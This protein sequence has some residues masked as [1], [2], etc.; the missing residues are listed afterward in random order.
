[1]ADCLARPSLGWVPASQGVEFKENHI[2]HGLATP[3][4]ARVQAVLGAY[5]SAWHRAQTWQ[6]LVYNRFKLLLPGLANG[7]ARPSLGWV[8]PGLLGSKYPRPNLL[9][10]KKHTSN[11]AYGLGTPSLACVQAVLG[12]KYQHGKGLN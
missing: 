3:N 11:M 7:L 9:N 4:L 8:G 2:K 10:A 12:S 6:T 5:V 1:M